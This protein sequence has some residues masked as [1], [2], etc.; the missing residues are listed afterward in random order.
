MPAREPARWLS[1]ARL[2][3][4]RPG[5]RLEGVLE[6]LILH[7]EHRDLLTLLK[8]RQD[9]R[10]HL[11]PLARLP[12]STTELPS[13]RPM[14]RVFS[15]GSPAI[16][17]L[18]SRPSTASGWRV[19]KRGSSPFQRVVFPRVE[20]PWLM[21]HG[22]P[23]VSRTLVLVD[24]KQ[25]SQLAWECLWKHLP[26]ELHGRKNVASHQKIPPHTGDAFMTYT[27]M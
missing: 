8:P 7:L 2:A 19:A 1:S 18:R 9:L 11:W 15:V 12:G 13:K 16:A 3:A 21:V 27:R 24:M 14:S 23:G 22:S 5:K 26:L 25:P 20:V 6:V 17:G 10:A 4:L